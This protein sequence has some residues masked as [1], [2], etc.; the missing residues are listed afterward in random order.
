MK[1]INTLSLL[2][3]L[4]MPACASQ[5]LAA[6]GGGSMGDG[7]ASAPVPAVHGTPARD[8][9]SGEPRSQSHIAFERSI[10]RPE[11][12]ESRPERTSRAH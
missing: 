3:F 2:L 11:R 9:A 7:G 8:L 6:R 4:A 5:G 12:S 1:T 10:E